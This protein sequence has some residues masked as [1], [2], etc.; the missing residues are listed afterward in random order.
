MVATSSLA[1]LAF[2]MISAGIQSAYLDPVL[3][4]MDQL[5]LESAS[6]AM[7]TG[8]PP[9]ASRYLSRLDRVFGTAHY[10]LDARG[11][12]VLSGVGMA[13]VLPHSPAVRSRGFIHG[14]FVVTHRSADGRYWLLSVGPRQGFR[15]TFLPYYLV[16]LGV[17]AILCVLAS[18]GVVMPM[19]RLAKIMERFGA[20]EL[21]AR[22]SWRRRDE[23]GSLGRSFDRMADR[24]ERLLVGERR[25][26]EDVSHE[27]RSPLARLTMAV[28]LARASPDPA[29][30]LDRIDRHLERLTSLTG[31]IVEMIRIEGDPQVQRWEPVDLGE[32]VAELIGDCCAEAEPRACRIRL[33]GHI[34]NPIICDRELVRRAL[35]N[36]LCNAVRFSPEHAA[37]DVE[38]H[39]ALRRVTLT[40]RDHGPGVPEG[41]LERIFEAF[42][43]TDEAR[44]SDRGG[45]G[46][47]LSIAKRA[48]TLH[49]GMITARNAAPGLVVTIILPRLQRP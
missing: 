18:L 16:S 41:A 2:T 48:V 40:V 23:I 11:T 5:E 15:W 28:K 49:G 45:V 7:Q 38:L 42:Y 17:A 34:A 6:E 19:R 33:A 31:A 1:L 4:A 20:G 26:L 36:V 24:I 12:D 47:G 10:L 46:L 9:A 8:G 25:L 44:D 22:S 14:R 43:R 29:A 37:I 27:L 35:E 21:S 3:Q 39:E 32:L 30:A 13:A